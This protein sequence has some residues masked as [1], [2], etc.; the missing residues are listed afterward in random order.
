MIEEIYNYL[1]SYLLTVN[2]K[3][4]DIYD[5]FF[6][7]EFFNFMSKETRL[8]ISGRYDFGLNKSDIHSNFD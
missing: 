1:G 4:S 3:V 8:S 2:Y 5:Q 7:N 6:I